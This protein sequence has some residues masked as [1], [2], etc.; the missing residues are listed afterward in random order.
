M[1]K[2]EKL[3]IQAQIKTPIKPQ[4]H[5]LIEKAKLLDSKDEFSYLRG[6][7]HIPSPQ[8]QEQAY[9]CHHITGLQPKRL[10]FYLEE[11]MERWRRN[12]PQE[13]DQIQKILNEKMALLV[14]AR[15]DEIILG[16]DHSRTS[17]LLATYFTKKIKILDA[18]D[19]QS[20]NLCDFKKIAG[21]AHENGELIGFDLSL[22]VG[23]IELNLHDW[24]IDFA[25]WN[26]HQYLSGGPGALTGVFIHQRHLTNN[27]HPHKPSMLSLFACAPL[28]ASLECLSSTGP[29]A[30]AA[31]KKNLLDFFHT[32]INEYAGEKMKIISS[33]KNPLGIVIIEIEDKKIE[34][35]ELVKKLR[36]SG[37]I[38][39]AISEHRLCFSFS[40]V[41]NSFDDVARAI[42]A[43]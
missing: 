18:F 19:F 31:K 8:A 41:A 32:G 21:H 25:L 43:I 42:I 40:A 16:H 2:K 30:T 13:Q 38:A 23:D 17:Q 33:R 26:G 36:A 11:L 27:A 6:K 7:F 12:D 39:D 29:K 1:T 5:P 34:A 15:A 35:Q 4:I 24:N 9:F 10:R 20:G 22:V 37:V 14:G 3:T 28:M